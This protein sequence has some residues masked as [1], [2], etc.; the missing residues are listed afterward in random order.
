QA[1]GGRILRKIVPGAYIGTTFSCSET[2]PFSD[3][4]EDI[5]AAFRADILLNRLFIEPA[6][7]YGY[8]R[9]DFKFL[10][11]LELHNKAWKFTGRM[12]FDF[13]FIGL[14]N[15]FPIVI[16]YNPLIP[17]IN[18]SEVK[19]SKRNVPRT[20]MGWE[21]N[22]ASFYR[23][24]KKFS[25]YHTIKDIII[26]ENGAS[27]KDRLVDGVVNDVERIDYF[28]Q[29]LSELLQAKREGM[30]IKGYFVWTLTDN[31]EWAEGYHP[32]FG[33]VH[34]DFKTQLRTVKNSG[35][36]FRDFLKR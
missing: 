10:E 1:E 34:V 32:R 5:Q 11:K 2:I 28:S 23:I 30:N 25:S 18:A 24:I 29:Y 6:L 19:A 22:A 20:A 7:G 12:Q 4:E 17:V 35:Y 15:Y 3:K 31:F 26:S 33:L 16:K 8:P 27:F 14:Q 21:V 36:W 13:D 9:E